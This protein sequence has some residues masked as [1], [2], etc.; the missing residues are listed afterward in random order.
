MIGFNHLGRLGRLGNQM[1]QFAALKGVAAVHGYE[2]CIPDSRFEDSRRNHQL[3]DAFAMP[4]VTRGGRKIRRFYQERTLAF[5][6]EWVRN[7]PDEVS[8]FGFFQSERYFAHVADAVAVDFTF[9]DPV[10]ARARRAIDGLD[11]PIALHVRRTDYLANSS[12][13]HVLKGAYYAAALRRFAPERSVVVFSD[14]PD[15][16][17]GQPMFQRPRFRVSASGSNVLD[18]CVMSLCDGHI[19]ANSSFSWW[20]AWLARRPNVEVVAPAQWFARHQAAWQAPDILP[21]RWSVVAEG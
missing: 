3:F 11:R 14:D 17:R 16:C 6:A 1:F 2:I 4:S 10:Q 21:E 20:G 18:L 19:I 8:L 5:D 7:C 9:R 13:H 12:K 15:W